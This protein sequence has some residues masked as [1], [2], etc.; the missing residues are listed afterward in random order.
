M[1]SKIKK[2][3]KVDRHRGR[4]KG[5]AARVLKVLRRVRPGRRRGREPGEA[6]HE[7]DT[8]QCPQGGIVEKDRPIHASN[9]MLVDPKTEQANARA[10]PGRRRRQEEPRC[11][12]ERQRDR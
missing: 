1:A 4:D 11:G 3:D 12:E 8:A 2:G 5:T 7:A 10:L 9:V 6:A